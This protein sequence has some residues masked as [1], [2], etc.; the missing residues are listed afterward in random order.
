V[1]FRGL[2][3]PIA[4]KLVPWAAPDSPAR[5][6]KDLSGPPLAVV[7]I[8]Y[9]MD[10]Q[11]GKTLLSLIPPYQRGVSVDEYE[12][13]LVDN[14]SP[15]PLAEPVWNLSPNIRY[16][17]VPPGEAPVNPGTAINRAVVNT[18]SPLLCVM[19]DGARILTPGVLRWGMDLSGCSTGALVDVRSWHLGHKSQNDSLVEG[20]SPEAER[21]LLASIDWPAD[22]YRLFDIGFPSNPTRTPFFKCVFE[23]NCLFISRGLF[24]QI[25]GYDERYKHPGGGLAGVDVFHRAVAKSDQVFTL[26]GEGTFHQTHGGAASGLDRKSLEDRLKIWRAEYES[27]SRPW[28]DRHRYDVVLAGHLPGPARRWFVRQ[29]RKK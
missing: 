26:L 5:I 14:G 18:N 7:V 6:A 11:I 10:Q 25:G 28:S 3:R 8:C 9:R 16:H 12:I 17:Y 21:Q 15:Q 20:Y 24:D 29:E 2:L 19:I 23:S 4:Q 22:G 13:H 1:S 27:L